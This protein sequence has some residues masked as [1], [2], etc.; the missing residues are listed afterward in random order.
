M[1]GDYILYGSGD[2]MRISSDEPYIIHTI[3]NQK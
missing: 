1:N 2:I 3:H